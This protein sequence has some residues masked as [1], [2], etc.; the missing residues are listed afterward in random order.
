M[1]RTAQTNPDVCHLSFSI[2][3]I[4]LS[5]ENQHWLGFV[6]YWVCPTKSVNKKWH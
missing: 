2:E 4:E 6:Y 3:N 5:R 1:G